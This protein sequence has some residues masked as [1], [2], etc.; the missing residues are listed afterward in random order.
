MTRRRI[1]LYFSPINIKEAMWLIVNF[2]IYLTGWRKRNTYH[3]DN[4]ELNWPVKKIAG[5]VATPSARSGLYILLKAL[6]ISRNDEVIITGYTCSAV[7]E[8]IQ[9]LGAKPVYVDIEMTTFGM[10]PSLL[11]DAITPQTKAIIIQHTYGIPASLDEIIKIAKSKNIFIIEDCALA[12]GSK[13][14]GKWLGQSGDASVFSFE[15]SKTLTAGWGG[16]VQINNDQVLT[17]NIISIR[18]KAGSLPQFTASRRLLQAG[19]SAILYRPEILKFSGYIIAILFKTGLFKKSETKSNEKKIPN[20]Y[21]A[22]PADPQWWVLSNQLH[23]LNEV[24]ECRKDIT[25]KYTLAISGIY[26]DNIFHWNDN[27]ILIRFP[28]LVKNRKGFCALFASNGIEVGSWFNMPVACNGGMSKYGYKSGQ[29]KKSEFIAEHVVNL[30]LHSLINEN[31]IRNILDC[32]NEYFVD[33]K[34]EKI[35]MS[36]LSALLS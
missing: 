7:P 31:D 33:N 10:D 34:E 5:A 28:L 21:L 9:F 16:L 20:E 2:F 11:K 30:P 8:P 4:F 1:S 23:R 35:F 36:E 26:P 22:A 24:L 13:Y 17:K 15:L 3:R 18:N 29:C 27:V 25:K 6:N 32:L 14:K 19:L 12:L